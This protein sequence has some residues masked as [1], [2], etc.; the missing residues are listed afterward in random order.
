MANERLESSD[1]DN[2][3][4]YVVYSKPRKEHSAQFHLNSKG[5]EVF[6]PRLLL[7]E[8]NTKRRRIVPLFPNYI[9]VRIRIFSQEYLYVRWS[10]GVKRFISFNGAP[11]PLD[12]KI[13]AFLMQQADPMGI[14]Q[15]RSNLKMGQEVQITGGPFDGL[16]GIIQEPPTAK[17]RVKIL[18]TL[19]NRETKVDVP[20]EFVKRGWVI[21]SGAHLGLT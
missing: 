4:W 11:A 5:L 19:L 17:G 14:I 16:I 13:V 15:A 18:L 20:V 6:F 8:S 2:H 3:R 1:L 7:P 12:E 10:P 9:F 21:A